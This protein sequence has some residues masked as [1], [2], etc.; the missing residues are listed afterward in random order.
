[1]S[2]SVALV[3]KGRQ[4][5]GWRWVRTAGLERQGASGAGPEVMMPRRRSA[6]HSGS[7]MC[8]SRLLLPQCF[9]GRGCAACAGK[10]ARDKTCW[11]QTAQAC[12]RSPATRTGAGG[13]R[14]SGPP[15]LVPPVSPPAHRRPFLFA[16]TCRRRRPG[17]GPALP[18]RGA[19]RLPPAA[20]GRLSAAAT[21]TTPAA[22][23]SEFCRHAVCLAVL[24]KLLIAF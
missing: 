15:S 7:S 23:L 16:C 1:M 21:H 4:T 12:R 11:L 17:P 18:L 3:C 14:A 8:G 10:F 13:R 24:S 22:T 6:Q 5:C 20:S 19:A 9:A 2:S